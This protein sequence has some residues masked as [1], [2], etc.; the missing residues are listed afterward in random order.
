MSTP[1]STVQRNSDSQSS[2]CSIVD[3][4]RFSYRTVKGDKETER[5]VVVFIGILVF[6]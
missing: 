6:D 4:K 2:V 1:S 5:V 3:E